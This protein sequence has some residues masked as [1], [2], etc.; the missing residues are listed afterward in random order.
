MA[1]GLLMIL[2]KWLVINH[3]NKVS[4][5]IQILKALKVNNTEKFF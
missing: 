3:H 4:L 2:K 5:H 1:A